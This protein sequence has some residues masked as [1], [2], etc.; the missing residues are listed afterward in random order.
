M[1]IVADH[2][3]SIVGVDTH[4]AP[5]TYA[6]VESP[7]G[8][9]IDQRTFPTTS[10]GLSRDVGDPGFVRREAMEFSVDEVIGGRNTL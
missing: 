4:P 7:S 5:H 8:K 1:T 10:A 9:L 6:L 3:T 2:F